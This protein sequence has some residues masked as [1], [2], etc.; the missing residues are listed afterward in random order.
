MSFFSV[1]H[2]LFGIQEP[3]Y[4]TAEPRPVLSQRKRLPRGRRGLRSQEP[5]TTVPS[6][7]PLVNHLVAPVDHH[8]ASHPG[9]ANL[10]DRG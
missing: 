3:I 6:S 1:V 10:T 5:Y 7:A 2:T 4:P 8:P 9:P